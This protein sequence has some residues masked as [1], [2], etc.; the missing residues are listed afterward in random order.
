MEEFWFHVRM[1]PL[2]PISSDARKGDF[3]PQSPA[4]WFDFSWQPL[5][6]L[7]HDIVAM[8]VSEWPRGR[9]SLLTNRKVRS[10][11]RA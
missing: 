4:Q 11:P 2:R 7:A 1:V 8:S 3:G 10:F 6:R 9:L 5:P